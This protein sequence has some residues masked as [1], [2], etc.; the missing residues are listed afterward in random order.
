MFGRMLAGEEK[1]NLAD[2]NR[3]AAV[4]VGH[5]I[6]THRA[7]AEDDYYTAMDDLKTRVEDAGADMIGEIGFGS[8]VYYLYVCVNCDLLMKNLSGDAELAAKG[9]EALAEAMATATPSGKQNS[10]AH[11]P[12]AQY[13]RAER[14]PQQPRD[15]T[16]AFFK[17]VTPGAEQDLLLSSIAELEAMA[18]RI[19]HSYGQC[20]SAEEIMNVPKGLGSLAAVKRFAAESVAPDA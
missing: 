2:F 14:G 3:E 12:R 6:T 20:W 16:G 13:L 4:Q 5:A 11:H 1:Y 17:P 7:L 9:L 18:G 8:G 15:L 10:F 19:D